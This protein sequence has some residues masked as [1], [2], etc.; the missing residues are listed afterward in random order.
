MVLDDAESADFQSAGLWDDEICR[1]KGVKPPASDF[2]PV[3]LVFAEASSAIDHLGS[4]ESIDPMD[5][6]NDER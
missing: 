4:T 2:K 1:Q 5:S 3:S 6:D